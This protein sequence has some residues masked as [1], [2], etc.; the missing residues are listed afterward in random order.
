MQNLRY[1]CNTHPEIST[2][3]NTLPAKNRHYAPIFTAD[4]GD[5]NE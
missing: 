4:K 5:R 2:G 1:I 3:K